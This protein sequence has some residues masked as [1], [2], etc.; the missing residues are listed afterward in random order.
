[1]SAPPLFA[2]TWGEGP[3]V[4]LL[5]GLGASS[6][7]WETMVEA[8]SGYAGVAPDLL[9][10]G[11]SPKPSDA[12]YDLAC[13]VETLAP[14]LAPGA[15]VVGHSTGA[16][17]APPSLPPVPGASAPCC[18]SGCR[19]SPTRR[20]RAERWAASAFWPASPWTAIRSRGWSASPCAG[21][22]RWRRRSRRW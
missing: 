7:Y 3:P 13:H 1:M 6:R 16:I 4:L 11:R 9:G 2:R 20:P 14:L 5:H 15:V 21:C 22:G 10:F 12:S 19:R 18:S 8:S 17:L